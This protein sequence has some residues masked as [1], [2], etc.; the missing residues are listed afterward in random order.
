[1]P[2]GL[3]E[4]PYFL[5]ILKAVLD[6]IKSSRDSTLLQYVDNLLF[7]SPQI[8]SQEGSIHLLKLLKDMRSPGENCCLFKLRFD[9]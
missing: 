6:D 8:S 9:T 4:S 3:T 5:Q 7:C 2:Q 1:M